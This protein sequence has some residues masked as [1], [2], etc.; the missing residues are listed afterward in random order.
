[1]KKAEIMKR[2]EFEKLRERSK[3]DKNFHRLLVAMLA[4]L[5]WVRS[6]PGDEIKACELASHI[7]RTGGAKWRPNLKDRLR[8]AG[9]RF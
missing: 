1:M 7:L 4:A 9:W 6:K 2:A 5:V 8:S 3:K